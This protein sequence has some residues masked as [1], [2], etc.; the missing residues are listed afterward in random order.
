MSQDIVTTVR[1]LMRAIGVKPEIVAALD[2]DVP[3][4]RQ[5]V[6]SIDFP[7]T[8]L[9]VQDRFTVTFSDEE[10]LGLRTLNDVAALVLRKLED[11]DGATHA[12]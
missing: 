5:G 12:S 1:D 3:L 10:L 2:P 6:D 8:A 4:R 7:L 11:G 9:A